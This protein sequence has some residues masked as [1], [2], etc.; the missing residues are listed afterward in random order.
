MLFRHFWPYFP[1]RL[2]NLVQYM[3]TREYTR[4]RHFV[5]LAKNTAR[6]HIKEKADVILM[7]DEKENKDVLSLLGEF[8]SWIL[9]WMW[10]QLME[11]SESE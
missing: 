4:F 8:G 10:T 2:L 3:P 9:A 5:E 7:E 6:E 1:Q 11:G